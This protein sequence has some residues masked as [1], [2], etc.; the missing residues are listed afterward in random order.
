MTEFY[1]NFLTSNKKKCICGG[2]YKYYNYSK[3]IKTKKHKKFI[4]LKNI[5]SICFTIDI[6]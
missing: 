1:Y 5:N 6:N 4:D 3:H 2:F